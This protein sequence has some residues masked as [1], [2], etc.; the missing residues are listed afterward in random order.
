MPFYLRLVFSYI[1]L[2]DYDMKK[3][4]LLL[5]ALL[6]CISGFA[7][8]D[9]I[10]IPWKLH[11]M[12]INGNTINVEPVQGIN[13]AGISFYETSPNIYEFQATA[14]DIN[15]VFNPG[16]SLIF[17]PGTFTVDFVSI[18]LGNCQSACTL[19]S[20][21]LFTIMMGNDNEMRTFNYQVIDLGGGNKQL[22]IDTPEGNR[23]VHGNF[24]LSNKKFDEKKI[25]MYPNPV[26]KKLFLDLKGYA[27][28][29]INV[30]SFVGATV[31]ESKVSQ[32]Q[33]TIDVSFLKPGIYIMKTTFKDGDTTVSQFIKE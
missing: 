21:Y 25:L 4:T 29:R 32:Q 5:C 31:F 24:T 3:T 11:S 10:D 14:G 23:A 8:Q 1:Y 6:F 7:Q 18:T 17:N 16:A 22:I 2:K 15:Y 30:L 33:N 26:K 9:L 28:E 13:N 12:V 20:Q 27:V 19:E